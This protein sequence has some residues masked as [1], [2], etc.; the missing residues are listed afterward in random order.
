MRFFKRSGSSQDLG[1]FS[2]GLRLRR[3][4][5]ERAPTNS[6]RARQIPPRPLSCSASPADVYKRQVLYRADPAAIG[7][8][9][10]YD[11]LYYLP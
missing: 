1:R 8:S 5:G 11:S 7:G 9:I 6:L 10:P 4:V 2:F 3:S